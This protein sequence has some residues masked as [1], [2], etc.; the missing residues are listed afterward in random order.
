[1][2]D[3]NFKGSFYGYLRD[4]VVFGSL[5][6]VLGDAFLD[7]RMDI[8]DGSSLAK[9]S[10]EL[11]LE[12]FELG[13]WTDNDDFGI[14]D[15]SASITDGQGLTLNSVY[16]DLYATVE[17]LTFKEYEY[18]DF[19]MDAQVDKNTFNGEFSISD[20]NIDFVFDGQ[21]EMK[22]SVPHLDFKA[23]IS[24]IDFSKL[25]LT[26]DPFAIHGNVDINGYG[27]DINDVVGNMIASDLIVS[28][29]DTIYA[30][31]TI[32]L[33]VLESGYKNREIKLYSDIAQVELEGEY[34]L[35]TILPSA[36]K[37][38]KNNYPHFTQNWKTTEFTSNKTQDLRFDITILSLIHI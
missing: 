31:D 19:I 37:L 2:G 27:R 29:N 35:A 6:S 34:D 8:K 32:S 21:I 38:L 3:I 30:L 5:K 24:Q 17:S 16:S 14:V 22:D 25:N 4:F 36:K 33:T 20:E 1:M 9:Y 12:R 13:Q 15:F 18:K 23:N 26:Q 10:G 28:A 11:S 7:M